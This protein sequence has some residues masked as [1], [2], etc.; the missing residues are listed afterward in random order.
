[1]L[2]SKT[3]A[4]LAC[5]FFGVP[6]AF[7]APAL[8]QTQA[9]SPHVSL[10]LHDAL[11]LALTNNLDYQAALADERAAEARIVQAR[12]TLQPNLSAG[13]SYDHTQ[14]AETFVVPTPTGFQKIAFSATN[15][16]SWNAALQYVL[17][18]GGANVATVGA[19][20]ANLEASQSD[21]AAEQATIIRDTTSAYFELIETTRSAAVADEAV[22]VA[23]EN[24]KTANELYQAG[25]SA[26]VDV[27]RTEVALADAR[28]DA[29][30]AHNQASLANA[31]LA[32]IL[33]VNL[34]SVIT[35]TDTL[36][37]IA[38]SY[39][40]DSLLTSALNRPELAAAYDAV[41]VADYAVKVARAGYY[42]TVA[43]GVAEESELPNFFNVPQPQ[44]SETLA[45]TWTLWNGG[46][47]RGKVQE[48]ETDVSKAKI[49]L[50]SLDN[51][52]DLEVREAFFNYT[53]SLA[54]VDAARD[55]QTAALENYRVNAIRF[56]AGVGTSLELSDA[57][58]SRTQA[59]N[60]YIQAL[61]DL[62]I[63]LVGLQ[64][65]AGL[66]QVTQNG[67]IMLQSP[68]TG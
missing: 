4:L 57:L 14:T 63:S 60:Q 51:N 40:L 67:G 22:S 16:N 15:T 17:Y 54:G 59:Q 53:A 12:S 33:N 47:S 66:I 65:A 41:S 19:A 20:S 68:P 30:K 13:Y 7:A 46:L 8:S 55:A 32:N 64:R 6:F 50:K 42:P 28:V 11:S 5:G 35:P 26:K 31:V 3:V 61:A 23:S 37:T 45:V 24:L 44:L 62:R 10:S 52:V 36:E 21:V 2:R 58:L 48:A 43:I 25:T 27:L 1:M 29:I 34:G 38:P 18:N 49:Q 9:S 39:T 56:R